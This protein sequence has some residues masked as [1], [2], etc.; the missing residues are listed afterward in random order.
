[1]SFGMPSHAVDHLRLEGLT[2]IEVAARGGVSA[3]ALRAG[4]SGFFRAEHDE[5]IRRQVAWPDESAR[6]LARQLARLDCWLRS[7]RPGGDPANPYGKARFW[8]GP[9]A[10]GWPR[11]RRQR[12][13]N[14]RRVERLRRS[15]RRGCWPR[16]A[17]WSW[18]AHGL[19]PP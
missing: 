16:P 5:G 12:R 2:P 9:H 10:S 1:V 19:A 3:D 13:V 17:A 18:R 11:T 4:I 15:L 6:I 7:P 8:H 14:D